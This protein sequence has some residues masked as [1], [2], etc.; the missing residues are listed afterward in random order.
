MNDHKKSGTLKRYVVPQTCFSPPFSAGA[1]L[2]CEDVVLK[3]ER[4]YRPSEVTL[5]QFYRRES[6]GTVCIVNS[7]VL[8][9]SL[10]VC[11]ELWNCGQEAAGGESSSSAAPFVKVL[12]ACLRVPGVFFLALR[13][14]RVHCCFWRLLKS[15]VVEFLSVEMLV[16][17]KFVCRA[18]CLFGV[19]NWPCCR[20][21]GLFRSVFPPHTRNFCVQRVRLTFMVTQ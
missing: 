18:A 16:G 5:E 4:S 2:P 9:T 6:E 3:V 11:C 12:H 1:I 13:P 10:V 17:Q 19:W 20:S 14:Q 7:I 21:G 8:P 15:S